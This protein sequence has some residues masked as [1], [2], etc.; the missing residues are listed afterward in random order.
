MA[1]QWGIKADFSRCVNVHAGQRMEE[2]LVLVL[3]GVVAELIQ[4]TRAQLQ[5]GEGAQ[6]R[7]HVGGVLDIKVSLFS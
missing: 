7:D 6:D 3:V 4:L 5:L 1:V 2:Q